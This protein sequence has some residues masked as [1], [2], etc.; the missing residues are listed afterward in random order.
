MAGLENPCRV[1]GRERKAQTFRIRGVRRYRRK[2]R[3]TLV[4]ENISQV[5][6]D[7]SCGSAGKRNRSAGSRS[8]GDIWCVQRDLM[9]LRQQR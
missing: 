5:R 4:K 3:N 1:K 8:P 7:D 9:G 6:G 2:A